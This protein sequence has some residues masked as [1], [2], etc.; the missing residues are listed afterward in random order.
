MEKTQSIHSIT[1]MFEARIEVYNEIGLS[2]FQNLLRTY[3]SCI[4][5]MHF[6]PFLE[7]AKREFYGIYLWTVRADKRFP[8]ESGISTMHF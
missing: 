8:L 1:T 5:S 4:R 3:I 7:H 6:Y 2:N